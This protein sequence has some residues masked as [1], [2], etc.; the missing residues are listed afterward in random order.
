M[1]AT[2]FFT[3]TDDCEVPLMDYA[4]LFELII[5]ISAHIVIYRAIVTTYRLRHKNNRYESDKDKGNETE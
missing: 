3:S 2:A 5:Y 1:E 4:K